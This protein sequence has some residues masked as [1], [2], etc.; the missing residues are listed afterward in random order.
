MPTYYAEKPTGKERYNVVV[1]EVKKVFPE[2]GERVIGSINLKGVTQ[3]VASAIMLLCEASN[4][5]GTI[6]LVE[7]TPNTART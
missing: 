2:M 7:E 3:E 6:E 1:P 4:I 5:P